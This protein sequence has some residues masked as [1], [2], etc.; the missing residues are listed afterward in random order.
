MAAPTRTGHP[1]PD[2]ATAALSL[3]AESETDGVGRRVRPLRRPRR[4]PASRPAS[5]LR[6]GHRSG[7]NT[8]RAVSGPHRWARPLLP[9]FVTSA[10]PVTARLPGIGPLIAY[11]ARRWPTCE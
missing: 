2:V 9:G 8:G 1:Q 3:A 4:D 5:G 11:S 7:G 6:P 10:T